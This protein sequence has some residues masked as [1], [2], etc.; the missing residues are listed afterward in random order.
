MS[1]HGD[2]PRARPARDF[3][4]IQVDQC[5]VSDLA[6]WLR[7]RETM[8]ALLQQQLLRAQ[9][10]MSQADKHRTEREF[11]VGDSVFLKLQPYIQ[12]SIARRPCQKLAFRYFGPYTIL[13]RVGPVAY[14]LNLPEHSQIHPVVHVSLL[15]KVLSPST[16]VSSALPP[17]VD[18]LHSIQSPEQVLERRLVRKGTATQAQ[19]L[20]QWEGL[21]SHLATWEDDAAFH[22]RYALP[23]AWGHAESEARETV[24][25]QRSPAD[26]KRRRTRDMRRRRISHKA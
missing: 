7:E 23:T 26:G 17:S 10:R 11:V 1:G 4:T 14:K 3:G 21:P 20:V 25:T 22:R 19:V 2:P 18:I 6:T 24:T 15:K 8:R 16:S 12:T 13:E 9:Q 5:T